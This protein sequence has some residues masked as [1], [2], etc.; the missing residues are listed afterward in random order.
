MD[1]SNTLSCDIRVHR[2][3]SQL[4]SKVVRS[5]FYNKPIKEFLSAD[6]LSWVIMSWMDWAG[7][8]FSFLRGIGDEGLSSGTAMCLSEV[9][10]VAGVEA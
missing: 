5:H 1:S 10:G 3:G 4:K 8:G 2:A 6:T 7:M 9:G